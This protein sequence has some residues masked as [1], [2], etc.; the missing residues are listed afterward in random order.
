MTKKSFPKRKTPAHQ[1]IVGHS[2]RAAIVFVTV[3]AEKRKPIF[4]HPDVHELLVDSWSRADGWA[5]GRYVIMPD[6]VHLFCAPGRCDAPGLNRW[7]QYWKTICSRKW[8]RPDEQPIWQ[9]SFWDTQLRR[10]ESY[11]SKWDYVRRN[12]VRAGLC[13]SPDNWPF[14]GV[15]RVL[16]WSE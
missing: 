15:V 8:P 4:A 9:R 5:V 13:A 11:S 2:D 12:P 3:C 7:I 6:H 10:G 16:P 14:Q 1:P